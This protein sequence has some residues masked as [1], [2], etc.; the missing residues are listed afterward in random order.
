MRRCGNCATAS[1][2]GSDSRPASGKE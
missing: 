2:T 1:V